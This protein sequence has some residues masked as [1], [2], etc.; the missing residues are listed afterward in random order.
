MNKMRILVTTDDYNEL[1]WYL[2]DHGFDP[3]ELQPWNDPLYD[4]EIKI[5]SHEDFYNIVKMMQKDKIKCLQVEYR[6][7]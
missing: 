1:W 7:I 4:I 2:K 3:K 6:S 5:K